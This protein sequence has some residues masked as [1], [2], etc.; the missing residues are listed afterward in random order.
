MYLEH[1]GLRAY[2]FSTTPDPRFY[3]P[4][5]KHREALACLLYAVEQRKGFALV[6]GEVGAGKSMLCR[7]AFERF[8]ADVNTALLVHTSLTAKQFFQAVCV[9]FG[10]AVK[11]K[12]KFELLRDIKDY[13]LDQSRINRT[14][15][16]IVDEA[17][18]LGRGV[19]EEVRLLGNLETASE[20]LIQIVLVGQPEL[21]TIIG[22]PELRQLNQRITIK[23]HLG[24]LSAEDAD[25][26]IDHRLRVA[27]A[28]GDPIFDDD[29][30]ARIFRASNGIPRLINVLCDH[31]LLEAFVN[32]WRSVE[33]TAV[34]NAI[35]EMDGYYMDAP[36]EVGS[37]ERDAS[38]SRGDSE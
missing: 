5:A 8:G 31:A 36:E 20:K 21:R 19:L 7:A 9:E 28:N 27:G 23:F 10:I 4:S 24:T 18:N 16:L 32:G 3:Y 6:S 2:P 11:G 29:A 30:K 34:R 22:A 17:Q 14:A 37:T 25:G 35:A 12:S 13:L 1:F 38:P 15:V 26:Y 33:E